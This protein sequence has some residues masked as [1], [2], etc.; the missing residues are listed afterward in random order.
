MQPYRLGSKSVGQNPCLCS[1]GSNGEW[2]T[3]VDGQANERTFIGFLVHVPLLCIT[4]AGFRVS[5][6][7]QSS[8]LMA[9]RFYVLDRY[10]M[11]AIKGLCRRL[12]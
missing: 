6:S 2:K 1:V 4:C 3:K 5:V 7:C 9:V 12:S 10:A 8:G 11:C